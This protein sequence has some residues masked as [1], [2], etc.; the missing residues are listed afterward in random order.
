MKKPLLLALSFI[1]AILGTSCNDDTRQINI[2]REKNKVDKTISIKF[3]NDSPNVPYISVKKF[4]LEFFKTDLSME[5]SFRTEYEYFYY[6]K[7]NEYLSFDVKKQTVKTNGI[8]SF[9]N[10]PDYKTTTGKLFIKYEN[11]NFTK[12]EGSLFNLGDYD[13]KF[14]KR[15]NEIYVPLTFLS[16][17]SGG[18]SGYD[19][20][21]NGKDIYVFD[22]EG[23]L[24]NATNYKTFGDEYLSVINNDEARPKDLVEYNYNELCFVFDKLR[25]NT[26]QLIFG[27][28]KLVSL[29]LN[30]LLETEHPKI[31][32]YL[33]ST[34]KLDYLEGLSSLFSGLSDGGHTVLTASFDK[35]T[36]A[37]KR[38]SE[39]DFVSVASKTSE[40]STEYSLN[41][42]SYGLSRRIVLGDDKLNNYYF[43]D[44]DSKTAVIGFNKFSLDFN[45]WDNFYNNL[46]EVPIQ[47]DTYAFVRDK[48]YQAKL[49]GAKNLVL[50]LT[51]N[52]GGSSY[53]LEG[54][55]SLFN[56][57]RGYIN[58]NDV[59]AKFIE[60][61][62][63]LIDINLDGKWDEDDINEAKS[64][65]FNVGVLTSC[66]SFS[67]GN[68]LPS[69]MKELGYKIIGE[70]SGGGSCA[71]SRDTTADGIPY[72]HSSF[73]CLTNKNGDNI[74]GGVPVD[75]AL[76]KTKVE[77]EDFYNCE[78]FYDTSSIGEYL[79]SAYSN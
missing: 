79:L 23:L 73:V 17:L 14:Y 57:G 50:D 78:A 49:D 66:V 11:S 6:T 40:V 7:Y 69:N 37:K 48:L 22:S 41:L 46:G 56:E 61:D 34:N 60:K 27:D 65:N 26:K 62:N 35:L 3:F 10:H 71:V 29:G 70:K 75:F 19:I 36:N 33:L 5:H 44:E 30:K 18:L 21:Y 51:T 1:P 74:D 43:Y 20:S 16:D 4:Y 8:Q 55:L 72:V 47:T 59:V 42:A 39:P 52:T 76:A 54:I 13:I 28:D 15:S 67:C 77:G 9:D 2:C 58:Y 12:R 25:G 68:L 24:G 64:F 53:A 32:E 38:E 45:G 63:H 31:K